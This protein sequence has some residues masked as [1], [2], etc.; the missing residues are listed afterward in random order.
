LKLTKDKEAFESLQKKLGVEV[1][2]GAADLNTDLN[3]HVAAWCKSYIPR[4]QSYDI[5]YN[6]VAA[7]LPETYELSL[8]LGQHDFNFK[9][10]GVD[11]SK[12]GF[13]KFDDQEGFGK[14]NLHYHPTVT[15]SHEGQIDFKQEIDIEVNKILTR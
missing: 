6:Q 8:Q 5:V 2:F 9:G 13:F 7:A 4:A 10:S 15:I 3:V 11:H 14:V 12:K 1:T